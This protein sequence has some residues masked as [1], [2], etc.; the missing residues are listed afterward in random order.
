MIFLLLTLCQALVPITRIPVT[1]TPPSKRVCPLGSY[2]P[3]TDIFMIFG[4]TQ[5]T[6]SMDDVWKFSL[7]TE[8][9]LEIVPSTSK[10]PS[11]V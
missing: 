1:S 2:S 3:T 9:W 5:E 11:N 7:D 4:G 6:A 10:S 8:T